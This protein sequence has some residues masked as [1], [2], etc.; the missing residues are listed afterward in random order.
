MVYSLCTRSSRA[1]GPDVI[2][3]RHGVIQQVSGLRVNTSE[4]RVVD[5]RCN[6]RRHRPACA[7]ARPPSR[8][9]LAGYLSVAYRS[10]PF[11]AASIRRS[12]APALP[13]RRPFQLVPGGQVLPAHASTWLASAAS[14]GGQEC[15]PPDRE[16]DR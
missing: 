5:E 2:S 11:S 12:A 3:V 16:H 15:D 6:F 14:F 9:G 13:R 10:S 8:L 4:S 1:G 7:V